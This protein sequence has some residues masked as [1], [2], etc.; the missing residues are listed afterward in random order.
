MRRYNFVVEVSKNGRRD[1]KNSL[2][3]KK[4]DITCPKKFNQILG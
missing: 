4:T 1:V 3:R 2:V